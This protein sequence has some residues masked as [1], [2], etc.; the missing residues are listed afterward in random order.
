MLSVHPRVSAA[1]FRFSVVAVV[2][3]GTVALASPHT[4]AELTETPAAFSQQSVTVVGTVANVV[5]RY[6]EKPYSTFELQDANGVQ[7]PVFVWR[8]SA[9][10]HGDVYKVSGTFVTEKTLGQYTLKD[11]IEADTVEKIS[12]AELKGVNTVFRKKHASR[13]KG[14]RGFYLPQ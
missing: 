11:G 2:L 1:L 8:P 9:W 4:I 12:E 10:K 6:G 3:V 7:L 13:I 5:T 14:V